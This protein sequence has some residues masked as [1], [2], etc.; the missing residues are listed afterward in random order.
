MTREQALQ[1]LRKRK[2]ILDSTLR[3]LDRLKTL[4]PSS[5]AP[6]IDAHADA[7]RQLEI[8]LGKQIDDLTTAPTCPAP[9]K[10][11]DPN[12]TGKTGSKFYYGN[13]RTDE[14][15]EPWLEQL[16]ALHLQLIRTGF[17]CDLIRV[18][19]FQWVSG[20]NAV[21][22]KGMYPLDSEYAYRFHPM[23]HRVGDSNFW[24]GP[25]PDSNSSASDVALYEFICNCWTWFNQ[26]TAA[27]LAE[28]KTTKD[29][30][31]GSLLDYTVVPIVTDIATP[32]NARSP[33]PGLIVGGKK[34]GM[35]GGQFV[36]TLSNLSHNAMW[37]AL[38]QA[39]FPGQDP[40][41]VLADE[42][43]MNSGAASVTTPIEGLWQA[44]A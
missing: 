38:A 12:L 36:N 23:T 24:N 17:Q 39:Y 3:E 41:K 27:A 25:P 26:K 28:F 20:T 18:A 14:N 31:G 13:E 6:K 9:P 8:A 4:A 30:F 10:A 1:T 37:L 44:P 16:G 19:T 34:L 35:I 33:L 7:I 42:A 40:A 22:F 21:A 5:Q 2:S 32:A 43:F 15:D 11:P 29:A